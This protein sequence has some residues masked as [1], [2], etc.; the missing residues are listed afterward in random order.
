LRALIFTDASRGRSVADNLL[1]V[2]ITAEAVWTQLRSRP[3][4]ERPALMRAYLGQLPAQEVARLLA[5][6][7]VDARREVLERL[8]RRDPWSLR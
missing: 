7:Q 4:A 2:P 1:L 8:A 3:A 6:S 5:L